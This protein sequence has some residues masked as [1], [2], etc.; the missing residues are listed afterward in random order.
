MSAAA[1]DRPAPRA[2]G[3]WALALVLLVAGL[4]HLANPE[5]FLAQVPP[6]F[7]ARDA[8]VL[9]SGLVEIALAV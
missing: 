8:V 6:W 3:R 1:A 4:G 5:V 9:G 2:V 7:P